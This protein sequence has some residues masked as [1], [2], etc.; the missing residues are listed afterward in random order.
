MNPSLKKEKTRLVLTGGHA[1][2][3]AMAVVKELKKRKTKLK[4]LE[5]Y[6]VGS[7]Y[8][9][10]GRKVSSI[11]YRKLPKLN[12]NFVHII[13]GK[14]QT[15]FTIWTIPS[16]LK[17]PLS[18][19][20]AFFVLGKI[21]PDLILSFGGFASVPV[22]FVGKLLG[23]KIIVHEQTAAIGR[24]N[25]ITSAVADKIILARSVSKKY[26]PLKKVI[27][28]GNP[29]DPMIFENPLRL[30]K[31]IPPTIFITGGSRG[32]V[33]L[34]DLICEIISE[35]LKNYNVVHQT[36]RMDYGRVKK[37]RNIIPKKLRSRYKVINQIEPGNMYLYYRK[38]DLVV[39]RAGANTVSEIIAAKK[40]A[41]FI[42]LPIAYLDEQRKNA[43]FAKDY[44]PAI[45]L[46]QNKLDSLA[47]LREIN[48][49]FTNWNNFV[50][51]AKFKES[52]DRKAAGKITDLLIDEIKKKQKA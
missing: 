4:N 41:I 18:F 3:T 15:R 34:N 8:A 47:L 6:W 36:G 11:E 12:V 1:A 52:P 16:L 46:N 38:A 13:T 37:T 43:E 9:Y 45:V 10:E 25:R 2:T 40:P 51:N 19:F 29:I 5:L 21:K 31:N 7:K 26:L 33:K 20:S 23:V 17:I 28:T 35:L 22:V 24:A 50:K 30:S 48:G 32:S 27:V 39:S 14:I 42:P 49:L 44:I